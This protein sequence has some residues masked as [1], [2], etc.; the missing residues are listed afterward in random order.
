MGAIQ[1]ENQN[2]N[3]RGLSDDTP[4]MQLGVCVSVGLGSLAHT[5]PQFQ[6]QN[7]HNLLHF[8]GHTI[9]CNEIKGVILERVIFL[10]LPLEREGTI[11]LTRIINYLIEGV[12][13]PLQLA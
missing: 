1:A 10:I 12:R 5:L 2:K 9:F 8:W 4:S 7:L 13:L 3:S 6:A 11:I